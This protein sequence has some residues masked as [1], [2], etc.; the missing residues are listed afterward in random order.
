MVREIYYAVKQF[1]YGPIPPGTLAGFTGP[2]GTPIRVKSLN[3][4]SEVTESYGKY[5]GKELST[6]TH[7]TGTPWQTLAQQDRIGD[8]IPHSLLRAYYMKLLPA[9]A[10]ADWQTAFA[11]ETTIH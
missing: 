8:I 3:L 5:T 7:K 6:A 2:G 10:R 11:R 1:G 9:G 4:I